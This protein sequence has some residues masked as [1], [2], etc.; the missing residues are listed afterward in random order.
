MDNSEILTQEG[1]KISKPWLRFI[2]FVSD[3]CPE[4]ELKVKFAA[5]SPTKLIS[6][7]PNVRFDKDSAVPN[8]IGGF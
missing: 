7:D 4:G 6:Y 2:T 5:G 1:F 3:V 8:K